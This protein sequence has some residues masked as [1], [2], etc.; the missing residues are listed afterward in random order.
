M[1]SLQYIL[2]AVAAVILMSCGGEK[3]VS[4]DVSLDFSSNEKVTISQAMEK[5]YKEELFFKGKIEALPALNFEIP[6]TVSGKVIWSD[7]NIGDPV[8][9]GQR[10]ASIYSYEMADFQKEIKAS[11]AVLEREKREFTAA[12]SMHASGLIS[13]AE[14]EAA[15]A[16]FVEAKSE[17]DKNMQ[18]ARLYGDNGQATFH[19]NS[20]VD[21]VIVTK[22]I[23][24]GQRVTESFE[25]SAFVVAD[26][27]QVRVKLNVFESDIRKIKK[28]SQVMLSTLA[29][30]ETVIVG[31]IDRISSVLDPES[32]VMS[33]YLT[34][35][36]PDRNLIPEMFVMA[37]VQELEGKMLTAVPS[38][39]VIFD[40][41]KNFVVKTDGKDY[42]IA[43][44]KLK[45][46]QNSEYFI[47]GLASGEAVVSAEALMVYTAIKQAS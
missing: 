3:E 16:E 9:K 11:K 14:F 43:E 44:V 1:K 34:L 19:I 17:Y 18:Q 4:N 22:N 47:E 36:N 21:G 27:S 12:E 37:K 46:E 31:Y 30:S 7:L 40:Q 38:K 6:S 24:K 5:N 20:P 29:D 32:K 23:R 28:G 45:G 26:L 39:A 15:K 13:A 25:E 35:D 41:D 8:K 10:L 33:A 2:L 42:E